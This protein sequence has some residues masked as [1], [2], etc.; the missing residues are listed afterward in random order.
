MMHNIGLQSEDKEGSGNSLENQLEPVVGTSPEKIA[1]K[2]KEC[3][4][5]SE[6]IE[7][8][9]NTKL[10]LN[11]IHGMVDVKPEIEK[12]LVQVIVKPE[13]EWQIA[14]NK[15]KAR[16]KKMREDLLL[17]QEREKELREEMES[18]DEEMKSKDEE[19]VVL[20]QSVEY[21]KKRAESRRQEEQTK[22]QFHFQSLRECYVRVNKVK[23]PSPP[24]LPTG[25]ASSKA[26]SLAPSPGGAD[27][28]TR[29]E[30]EGAGGELEE[31]QGEGSS[32]WR[33]HKLVKTGEKLHSCSTCNKA[34]LTKSNIK[35]HLR[36]HSG[37]KPYSCVIC[38]RSFL[39]K[40]DLKCHKRTHSGEKPYSCDICPKTF[41]QAG[42]LKRHMRTH[43]EEKPYTCDVCPSSFLQKPC[44]HL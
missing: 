41:S 25:E 12:N 33:Q 1:V 7:E 35:R 28:G 14:T 18:K 29:E 32:H 20:K 21:W 17:A 37:E 30:Q 10:E 26:S 9:Y 34:F 43:S 6:Y 39:Q 24:C 42:T 19:I 27:T 38:L 23:R 16:D 13:P 4:E 31:E 2:I 5:D 22:E 40:Y 11:T 3:R 8:D 15:M 44:I 36:T